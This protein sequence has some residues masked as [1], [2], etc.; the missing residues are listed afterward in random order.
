MCLGAQPV[1]QAARTRADGCT[2]SGLTLSLGC[3]GLLPK[4]ALCLPQVSYWEGNAGNM[5]HLQ[6]PAVLTLPGQRMD[7]PL[8]S[9]TFPSLIHIVLLNI[10]RPRE[11]A[12]SAFT[13]A[14]GAGHGRCWQ[15]RGWA[16]A[17]ASPVR[18]VS[19]RDPATPRHHQHEGGGFEARFVRPSPSPSD[20]P[21]TAGTSLCGR[22]RR[23]GAAS[24]LGP[25]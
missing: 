21:G 13:P 11:A 3:P 23:R 18:A 20:A 19:G 2:M 5:L 8:S 7:L 6:L 16:A 22:Q 24:H 4:D 12:H 1:S 17:A 15:E 14:R 25:G 10:A 9:C